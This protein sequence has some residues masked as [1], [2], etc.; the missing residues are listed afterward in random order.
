[1]NAAVL[2]VV[3]LL[4]IGAGFIGKGVGT[5]KKVTMTESKTQQQSN[6]SSSEQKTDTTTV[7]QS[8]LNNR[9]LYAQIM[10]ITGEDVQIKPPKQVAE[11]ISSYKKIINSIGLGYSLGL[12]VRPGHIPTSGGDPNPLVLLNAFVGKESFNIFYECRYHKIGLI[13]DGAYQFDGIEGEFYEPF[14]YNE[15]LE[16]YTYNITDS[17]VLT[18]SMKLPY[19]FRNNSYIAIGINY[20]FVD[21]VY[22]KSNR[23]IYHSVN[24]EKARVEDL[25]YLAEYV[26]QFFKWKNLALMGQVSYRYFRTYSNIFTIDNSGVFFNLGLQLSK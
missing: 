21:F 26:W 10:D 20:N 22:Q 1:M 15:Q 24:T 9:K 12:G 4:V 6:V 3:A 17:N 13:L 16:F 25:G 8:D 14:Y 18:I 11:D 2:M 7:T 5:D 23:S 19:H